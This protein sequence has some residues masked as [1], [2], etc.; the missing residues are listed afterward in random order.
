[1]E[2][3]PPNVGVGVVIM[4]QGKVL[5]I[6]RNG[7]H[8]GGTWSTPGGYLEMGETPEQCAAREAHEETGIRVKDAKF[9]GLTNDVFKESGKHFITIWI[10]AKPVDSRQI[11]VKSPDELTEVG[12]FKRD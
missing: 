6:R 5:M 7:K 8:G 4:H 9:L 12:W 2:R 11:S 10:K 3:K 1:M